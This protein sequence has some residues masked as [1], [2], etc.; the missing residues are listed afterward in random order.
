MSKFKFKTKYID[1]VIESD[2]A[3]SIFEFLK[4]T[5]TW[6]E[7]I[8]SKKGFTR[9][10]KSIN[11]EEYPELLNI[12]KNV[13]FSFDNKNKYILCGTYLNYY[14]NGEMWTPNHSHPKMHQLVISLGDIRT[15]I[16][17]KKEYK[18][19]NGSAIMFG[20]SVHGVPKDLTRGQGR[21]SIAVFLV[22]VS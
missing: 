22:L 16:V 21:I 6:E 3:T 14:K 11:L 1:N 19:A 20:S 4:D 7:G 12:V 13:L 15:L 17:G 10:A 8:R 18:M 9:L 2:T 5:I